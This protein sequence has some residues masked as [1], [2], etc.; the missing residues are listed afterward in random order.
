MV[1]YLLQIKIFLSKYLLKYDINYGS[2]I[3]EEWYKNDF[4]YNRY[5]TTSN[6]QTCTFSWFPVFRGIR[7]VFS[8][9]HEISILNPKQQPWN[10]FSFAVKFFLKDFYK[11]I[12]IVF[13]SLS[14]CCMSLLVYRFRKNILTILLIT[15]SVV[16]LV[17]HCQ[18]CNLT[19]N[20]WKR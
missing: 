4:A 12:K 9:G 5:A 1:S 17:H 10:W 7:K 18:K 19:F 3:V 20:E 16:Y 15:N 14:Y 11:A 13:D 2:L 8:C 6:L